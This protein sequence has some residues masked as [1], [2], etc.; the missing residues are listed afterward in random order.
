MQIRRQNTDVADHTVILG[1]LR[2]SFY[3]TPNSPPLLSNVLTLLEPEAAPFSFSF[4][5]QKK[6]VKH[7]PFLN[8]C[9][10]DRWQVAWDSKA[11]S[12]GWF[13]SNYLKYFVCTGGD[14]S[15]PGFLKWWQGSKGTIKETSQVKDRRRSRENWGYG[16]K[17]NFE[18]GRSIFGSRVALNYMLVLCQSPFDLDTIHFWILYSVIFCYE[19]Y[20]FFSFS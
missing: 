20:P 4:D 17:D 5:W 19:I 10:C 2:S 15:V 18:H 14:M 9:S 6:T 1:L 16:N 13:Q 12:K 11:S 8:L 7:D 3:H